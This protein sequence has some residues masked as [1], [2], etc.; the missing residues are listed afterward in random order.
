MVLK[1]SSDVKFGQD[2][3]KKINSANNELGFKLLAEVEEDENN[4]VF[5]SPTSLLMA[6]SMVYNG[7]DGVTKEE[8]AQSVTS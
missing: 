2:D 3:Y 4:N 1:I 8:I 6:L 5:V 7:A